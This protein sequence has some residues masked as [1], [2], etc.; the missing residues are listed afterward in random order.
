MLAIAAQKRELRRFY[1]VYLVRIR[2]L[3]FRF[4]TIRSRHCSRKL[5]TLNFA[6]RFDRLH[7]FPEITT[8]LLFAF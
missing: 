4:D 5:L 8:D 6:G 2:N 1:G 7:R 3:Q